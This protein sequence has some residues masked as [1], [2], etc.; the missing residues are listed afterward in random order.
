MYLILKSYYLI[1]FGLL[2]NPPLPLME[3]TQMKALGTTI[4][5]L[6]PN[7]RIVCVVTPAQHSCALLIKGSP[8]EAHRLTE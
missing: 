7:C 8:M 5:L 1:F 4:G 2:R 6:K 3:E